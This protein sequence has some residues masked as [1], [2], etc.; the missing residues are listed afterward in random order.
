MKRRRQSRQ[1]A[2]LALTFFL[3]LCTMRGAFIQFEVLNVMISTDRTRPSSYGIDVMEDYKAF[4]V[5]S[6]DHSLVVARALGKT[7][8]DRE[9]SIL[10]KKQKTRI[11][12]VIS[13]CDSPV[14]WI[15][16]FMGE[17]NFLVSDITIFS[18]CGTEVDGVS[19]LESSFGVDAIIKRLPNVGR[20]DHTYAHWIRD[21]YSRTREE[22]RTSGEEDFPQDLVLF[23][24][25][26]NY[27]KDTYIPFPHIFTTAS[28]A[29]FG[30]IQKIGV[31]SRGKHLPLELHSK[32]FIEQFNISQ[33]SRLHRDKNLV[34][35]S[36]FQN[37]GEWSKTLGL[38]FPD[39]EYINVCYGGNFLIQKR[40]ILSQSEDTWT[41]MTIS[42]SRGDNIQEGHFAERAWA[43]IVAPP[44]P[45]LPL[46]VL[47]EIVRPFV[48]NLANKKNPDQG[49]LF[50]SKDSSFWVMSVPTQSPT[51]TPMKSS[52]STS[53][54]ESSQTHYNEGDVTEGGRIDL[55]SPLKDTPSSSNDVDVSS[56]T[57]ST[58][59]PVFYNIFAL[60]ENVEYVKGIV[61]EQMSMSLPKHEFLVRSIG[62]PFTIQNTSLLRHDKEGDEIETLQLLWQH[63]NDHPNDKVIYIHS[64]GSFHHNEDKNRLRRFLTRGALSDEC[65][66]LPDTCNVCSSRMSPMPHPHA[67]GNMWLARCEY[68]KRLPDPSKFEE[69]MFRHTEEIHFLTEDCYPCFGLGRFAA[70]HWIHSHPSVK[71]CDLSSDSNFV[72]AYE[73]IPVA[74]FEINLEAAPRFQLEVYGGP[75]EC[76][77]GQYLNYRLS[78][79]RA[80]FG[81]DE[82]IPQDWFGWNLFKQDSSPLRISAT[83]GDI[84]RL[85][86][87]IKF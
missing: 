82:E 35:K 15:A 72:V 54:V 30:C 71:P 83:D 27:H 47:S 75:A 70:E 24:K 43:S 62:I 23:I 60:S 74:E 39:S 57:E 36:N 87:P 68:V 25:D 48:T 12:I 80:L 20:C 63:C 14:D 46:D 33:Y 34:F 26:N 40:G 45:D 5:S 59:I 50:I 6:I 69:M 65:A 66:H 86:D 1:N 16:S 29:G 8:Q 67:L 7:T 11:S 52:F 42:L 37:L 79:Y 2:L 64:K 10:S 17:G 76:M 73:N 19:A 21:N 78:E 44:P 38:V 28:D 32:I 18:K 84:C 56:A 22:L 49:R 4:D 81:D 3:A 9:A 61:E 85:K 41:N 53:S 51:R 77:F 31:P 58:R 13:H 55:R